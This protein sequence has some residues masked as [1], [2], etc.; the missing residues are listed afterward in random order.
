MG[1]VEGGQNRVVTEGFADVVSKVTPAVVTIRTE[2]TASP[3]LTQLPQLPDGFPFG[4][5]FGQ[6]APRGGRQAPAPMQRGLGSG[7]IVS[8]DGYILTN[9][10]V[11]DQAARIQVELSDRRVMDATLVGA[12]QPS[13]LAVVKIDG[14]NLPVVPIGDSTAMR[15]GDLVLAVGNPLGVGQTVTMGI[16]SA[17][18]RATGLG[19][20]SYE[21]FLQT[22]APINQGNSGGALVNTAGELVGINSQ[23]LSPSGGNIGIGFA[24][25]SNMAKNVMDQLVANGRVHRGRLGVTVQGMT[26][27]LAAGLGLD[28]TTG[29]LVSDVSPGSAAAKAGLR[30]GDVILSYQGRAIAD[31]NAFRNEIAG[32]KPGSTVSLQVLRDGRTSEMKATLEEMEVAKTAAGRRA[33]APEGSGRFGLTVQPLTPEIAQQ[34]ELDRDTRGVVITDVDPAGAAASAGLREGDVIQQVNGKSIRTVDEL[35]AGLDAVSERPAVLLV[36][37]GGTSLFVPLRAKRG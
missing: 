7:V 21:D 28:K 29:A 3:Q 26:G 31:T 22:D 34:L 5:F 6:R 30:R 1:R 33:G 14:A 11:V 37:R 17:K 9:H 27:D 36:A 2:R 10:H 15:V 8:A 20:G 32:T 18:G 12:D 13:D 4:E 35:R 23:I 24:V 16:V 19:D 25:P